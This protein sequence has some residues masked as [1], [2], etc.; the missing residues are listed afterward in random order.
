MGTLASAAAFPGETE[1]G[2]S[3]MTEAVLVELGQA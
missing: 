3:E 2:T 1:V